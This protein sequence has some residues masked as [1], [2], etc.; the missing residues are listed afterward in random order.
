MT[1][2]AS[3][4]ASVN[5]LSRERTEL[6]VQT[7]GFVS[8]ITDDMDPLLAP[9]Q[10]H[11]S[12]EAGS[13]GVGVRGRWTSDTG[14]MVMGGLMTGDEDYQGVQEDNNITGTLAVRYAP[15][16]SATSR[17]FVEVGGLLGSADSVNFTRTYVNGKGAAEGQ[18]AA[19]M[20]SGAAWGRLGWIWTPSAADQIGAFAEYQYARQALGGYLEPL[21]QRD[22]FEA[23]VAPGADEMNVGKIGLRYTHTAAA[24][25]N[26]GAGLAVAHAFTDRQDLAVAVDGFGP[27]PAAPV[28]RETWVEYGVHVGYG[29]GR[30]S[31]LSLFAA[32]VTGSDRI[33]SAAHVGVDYKVVF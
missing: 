15:A 8:T 4:Q 22:P 12:A 19:S 28:H 7:R 9:S 16:M 13:Y 6:L 21:S 33:G 11:V 5:Q 32:G 14:L 23:L 25:W 3:V 10:I 2:Q 27:V 20:H 30:N 31:T 24:G 1:T 29:L 17:P 18:G 26:Y